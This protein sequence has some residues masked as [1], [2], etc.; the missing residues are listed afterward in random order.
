[1][2]AARRPGGTLGQLPRDLAA[3][4][5]RARYADF[6]LQTREGIH[7]AVPRGTPWSPGRYPSEAA[8]RSSS[9]LPP[10]PAPELRDQAH[11]RRV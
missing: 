3:R 6:G 9:A 4:L 5:F 7:V 10:G 8:R 1:M 2:T 11:P